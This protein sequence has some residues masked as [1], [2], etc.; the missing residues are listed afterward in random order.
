LKS[1]FAPQPGNGTIF[2]AFPEPMRHWTLRRQAF[3]TC[4]KS[5]AGMVFLAGLLAG[6]RCIGQKTR[7]LDSTQ[8]HQRLVVAGPS[9]DRGSLHQWLWG[10]DYRREWLTPVTVPVLN[11]DS[12][13][14]GLTPLR[15]GGGTQT[16]NLRLRDAKGR[17]WMLR[18]VDK[19]YMGA[20]PQVVEGTFVEGLANDQVAT[21]HPYA[22]LAVPVLAE[23]AGVFHTNPKYYY[24]PYH[25]RLGPFNERFANT[26]CLLEERPDTTQVAQRS[27]GRPK[28]II[29][30]ERMLER[31][32]GEHHY[33][34]DQQ[35]YVR[36]RLFDMFLGDWG[37][38]KDNWRWARFDSGSFHLFRPVPV[39]RDQTFARFEGTMVR[40]IRSIGRFRE[41]QS[42]E[43]EIKNVQWYNYPAFP[44]DK[45]LTNALTEEDWIAI[46][47]QLQ[48]QLTDAVIERALRQLPPPIF[49]LS[50]ETIIRALKSR[51]NNLLRYAT[52]YYKFLGEEVEIPA[53]EQAEAILV[54]RLSSN[55]T[56]VRIFRVD[57]NGKQDSRPVYQRTFHHDETK[58]LRLFGLGGN[59]RIEVRGSTSNGIRIRVR[60]GTGQDTLIDASRVSGGSRKT[61]FYDNPGNTVIASGETR[62]HLSQFSSINTYDPEVFRWDSRGLKP[63]FFFNRFYRFYVGLGYTLTKDRGRDGSFGA[64]HRIGIN[65]SVIE[66]SF[67]PYYSSSFSEA[68]GRWNLHL[69]AGYDGVRRYNFF[70]VGNE[71]KRTTEDIRYN[72]LRLRTV[73][74]GIGIDQEFR[75]KHL[76]RAD[77]QFEAI[78]VIDSEGTY[79]EKKLGNLPA[80]VFNWK[81]FLSPRI[82]YAYSKIN[83]PVVPT[84]GFRMQ[85]SGSYTK[86]LWEAKSVSRLESGIQFYWPLFRAFSF[87]LKGGAAT[88]SGQPEL[89]QLNTLGG[90]YDLRGYWRFRFYG[91]SSF[92]TQQEIRWLPTVHGKLFSGRAGLLAFFDQGRVWQ[93]GEVSSNWH[94]S[95]GGG[96]ILVPFNRVALSVTYGISEETKRMNIRLGRVF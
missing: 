8:P 23:A 71:S 10:K 48:R 2:F 76:L 61:H 17:H 91:K 25:P 12:A 4:G 84:R 81:Q 67:H 93:P 28:D 29:S 66:N 83:D 41:L 42:F 13:F 63:I 33:L 52:T 44:L 7:V 24:V 74:A 16:K 79:S 57:S 27:F 77:L 30:T 6:S 38:Q 70:G 50:G 35:A 40:L 80:E 53:T 1:R 5:L 18:M 89:Y 37:R 31:L 46:A 22:A 20:L 21:L 14:G 26:L 19:T 87:A 94:L 32:R 95:I 3:R 36:A 34:V 39:D 64:R 92:F 11:L 85:L 43:E 68:L 73:Y 86:N 54:D 65:Y 59:D 96:V 62:V 58:E 82:T 75:S 55:E 49:A 51:R 47:R 72:W 60:G 78:R 15:E 69:L 88:L 56:A 9:Y 45:I 90:S